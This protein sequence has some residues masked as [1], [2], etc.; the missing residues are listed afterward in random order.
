MGVAVHVVR[1]VRVAVAAVAVTAA[2][3]LP[4][5]GTTAPAASATAGSG[6]LTVR[7]A[8]SFASGDQD[9]SVEL[10]QDYPAGAAAGQDLAPGPLTATV[11]I[12][13]A[14]IGALLPASTATLA[15]TARLAVHVTQGA[16]ATDVT[17]TG[18]TAAEA[19]AGGTGDVTLAFTGDVPP[20]AA[21]AAGGA[22]IAVDAD[23]LTLVL[24]PVAGPG[25]SPTAPDTGGADE[26]ATAPTTAPTAT[27]T[28]AA[29]ATTPP[30]GLDDLVGSCKPAPDQDVRLAT[31]Q[32]T[33]DGP[34]ASGTPGSG[35]PAAGGTATPSTG[36]STTAPGSAAP[37]SPKGGATPRDTPVL[38]DRHDC[39]PAPTGDPDPAVLAAQARKRPPNAVYYPPPGAPPIH[40][41][42]Q[43]GYLTGLSNVT[44]LNGASVLNPL[45]APEPAITDIAA[46][47]SV[48]SFS[49]PDNP[50]V[51]LDSVATFDI[52]PAGTAFL[53]YGFM[54]TTATMHL[55][56][57]GG[58]MTVISTGTIGQVIVNEIHGENDLQLTDV[59]LNGTPLDV[60]P[61]CRTEA[62]LDIDLLGIDRS[63]LDGPTPHDYKIQTG[64]PLFQDD[65]YIP[66]FHGCRSPS[67]E[68]L[69]ALFTSS[70][71]G[72]GNSLNLMQGPLC[73][74]EADTTWCLPAIPYPVP[75]HR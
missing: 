13:R 31:V 62:P 71:S 49:D 21:G 41:I 58:R 29:G 12:P 28:T 2:G 47:A 61:D 48:F 72:H 45:T 32:V 54:P 53:T 16:A 5:A 9:V 8:C 46:V 50:Y 68:N 42:A 51:E 18:L 59:R 11:V 57:R 34:S 63:N 22:D 1:A 14:G 40:R 6:Q 75:P 26:S 67:G 44:K 10:R 25:A 69:D 38:S 17:W 43:C 52:P 70:I 73:I 24:H 36:P 3:L 56:T 20:L 37:R 19:P 15:G 7:Y 66:P 64:G 30:D 4:W 27:P 23:I 74:P 39:P 60:G 55:T 33:G 65:L 35:S